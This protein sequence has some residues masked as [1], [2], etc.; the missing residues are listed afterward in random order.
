M[1]FLRYLS[2]FEMAS[3]AISSHLNISGM[4]LQICQTLVDIACEVE[5]SGVPG[6]DMTC[7]LLHEG[8]LK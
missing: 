5:A 3:Q 1:P 7:D 4:A 8:R 6:I 2:S